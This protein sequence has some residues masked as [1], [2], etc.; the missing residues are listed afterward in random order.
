MASL[1]SIND[2]VMGCVRG[3]GYA[4]WGGGGGG[5]GSCR[6]AAMGF[7]IFFEKSLSSVSFSRVLDKKHSTKT[8]LPS[9][10]LLSAVCRV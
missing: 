6:R 1:S 7:F 10:C 4:R 2:V 5:G 3:R 8:A 9:L